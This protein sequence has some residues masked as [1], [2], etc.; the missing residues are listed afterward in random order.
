MA[1]S[2]CVTAELEMVAWKGATG[3]KEKSE[4]SEHTKSTWSTAQLGSECQHAA[5]SCCG[6]PIFRVYSSE[7]MWDTYI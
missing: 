2:S 3:H 6:T 4:V 5:L 7:L 1:C